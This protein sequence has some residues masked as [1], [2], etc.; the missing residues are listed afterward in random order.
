MK[1][2]E[3]FSYE[4][5]LNIY[6]KKLKY[7]SAVGIDKVSNSYFN[8]HKEEF[9]L[10]IS[11]KLLNK[12]YRFKP[13]KIMLK[14]KKYNSLPRKICVSTISDR[15]VMEAIREYLLTIFTF[16]KMHTA[17]TE[18][19]S[20]FSDAYKS[21][22]YT[23]IYKTD[24]HAFYDNVNHKILLKKLKNEKVD[25]DII[26]LIYNILTNKQKVVNSKKNKDCIVSKKGIPQGLCI[27]NILANI[28]MLDLD[29]KI[30][31]IQ[32]SIYI[33]YVDDI[34]IFSNKKYLK[35]PL[36]LEMMKLGLKLNKEK[37]DIVNL[38][39]NPKTLIE[40]IGY[41]IKDG[42]ISVRESS[43]KS[44]M[45]SIESL[46]V[47]YKQNMKSIPN[48]LERLEWSLNLRISGAIC[49]NKRYGWLFYFSRVED[50]ALIKRLDAFIDKMIKRYN[51]ELTNRKKM[52]DVFFELKRKSLYKRIDSGKS[53]IMNLDK[54]N[55]IN[56]MIGIILLISNYS[57]GY[58]RTLNDDQIVI[59]FRKLIF[60]CMKSLEMDLD[61]LS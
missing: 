45:D 1:Y 16:D 57:E 59:L 60:K 18:K 13:Y 3:L 48:S 26:T 21:E 61:N 51:V 55:D 53:S 47:S 30:S 33:R 29:N 36:K 25:D 2:E 43:V 14:V 19:V 50:S 28:Y 6:E 40:F 7:V 39:E 12:R 49:N 37:T 24:V 27:S 46:F 58:I 11:R 8:Y 31:S 35:F 9:I 52:I 17:I 20:I 44:F 54:I 22:R 38:K 4:N 41:S 23:L 15:L 32:D 5:L 34:I 42:R 56:E 10:N